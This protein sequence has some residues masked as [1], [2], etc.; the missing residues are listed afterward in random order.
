RFSLDLMNQRIDKSLRGNINRRL[1]FDGANL[2][3]TVD[4]AQRVI[5]AIGYLERK[6]ILET[7][8]EPMQKA[9]KLRLSYPEVSLGELVERSEDKIT[10]SGLNHRLQKFVLLAQK[11][12]QEEETEE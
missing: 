3:K 4:G 5:E 7:L 8:P 6:G 10:K 1:N 2:K 12:K 9:A 11:V